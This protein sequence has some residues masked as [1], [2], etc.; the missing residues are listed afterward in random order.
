M[1][2]AVEIIV[3]RLLCLGE[4]LDHSG[5]HLL[6]DLRRFGHAAHMSGGNGPLFEQ[7]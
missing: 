3:R 7:G 4:G 2:E 5:S 6:G 1:P